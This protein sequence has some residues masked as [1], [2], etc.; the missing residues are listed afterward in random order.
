MLSVGLSLGDN[1]SHPAFRVVYIT[2]PSRD[3]VNMA[4]EDGLPC[5]FTSVNADVKS[6]DARVVLDQLLPD[7]VGQIMDGIDLGLVQ[8]KVIRNVPL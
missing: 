4:V 6:R 8:I 3:Q 5:G 1:P 2:I 7:E